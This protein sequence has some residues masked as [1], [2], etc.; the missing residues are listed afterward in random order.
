M[1]R[2]F[3][4]GMRVCKVCSYWNKRMDCTFCRCCSQ[5]VP[6]YKSH[7][8]GL[9]FHIQK[10]HDPW[11]TRNLYAPLDTSWNF[12]KYYLRVMAVAAVASSFLRFARLGLHDLLGLFPMLFCLG[13]MLF[14]WNRSAAICWWCVNLW[15]LSSVNTLHNWRW[16]NLCS[17]SGQDLVRRNQCLLRFNR[18]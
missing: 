15:T 8:K 3:L 12:L 11:I 10:A 14:A 2:A 5:D 1:L 13:V 9:Q 7:E 6:P 18:L 16:T 4:G 17:K